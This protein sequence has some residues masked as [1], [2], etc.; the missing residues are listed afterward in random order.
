M[1]APGK[2]QVVE[3]S[4]PLLLPFSGRCSVAGQLPQIVCVK[5]TTGDPIRS[6]PKNRI[7]GI[8]DKVSGEIGDDKGD[9][10]DL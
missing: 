7:A 2:G 6:R 3:N 5:E 4:L 9:Y 8:G 10:M 1:A